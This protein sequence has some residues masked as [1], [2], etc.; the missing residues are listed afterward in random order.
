MRIEYVYRAL[1][2]CLLL[3]LLVFYSMLSSGC[4][5]QKK[6][7]KHMLKAW[8]LSP[9][10]A[11][12]YCRQV[13]PIKEVV[14]D[15][16]IY[17]EGKV[18]YET[19]TLNVDCDSIK[20]VKVPYIKTLRKTDTIYVGKTITQFDEVSLN[21]EREKSYKLGLE[22]EILK[23]KNKQYLKALAACIGL[24]ALLTLFLFKR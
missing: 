18:I 19:D 9:E 14:K 5:A 12:K 24:L 11:V 16:I 8:S 21:I 23:S 17:I 4:N 7:T 10:T 6:A 15:S 20:I 13:A 2:A 1:A 3:A 22:K